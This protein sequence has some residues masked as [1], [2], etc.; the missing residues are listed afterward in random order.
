MFVRYFFLNGSLNN[1]IQENYSEKS[2]IT[3]NSVKQTSL[4]EYINQVLI[5]K[6]IA[7]TLLQI[8][9][10]QDLPT[11]NWGYTVEVIH[12]G[13]VYVRAYRQLSEGEIYV[14]GISASGEWIGD[15]KQL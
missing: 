3:P 11:S 13:A 5:P 7:Y 6:R 14:R 1:I 10:F 12:C 15:W 4:L 2:M 8:Q 9:C